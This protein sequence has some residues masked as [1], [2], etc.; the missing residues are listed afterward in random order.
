[1][2]EI[3]YFFCGNCGLIE[4]KISAP[5]EK[6]D[7]EACVRCGFDDEF[8]FEPTGDLEENND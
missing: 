2:I 4:S 7:H 3:G 1:V 6:K 5:Y 8:I